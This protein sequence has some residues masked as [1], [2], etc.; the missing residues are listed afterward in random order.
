MFG[1]RNGTA[2]CRE[3]TVSLVLTAREPVVRYGTALTRKKW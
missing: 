2:V 1:V 3:Q